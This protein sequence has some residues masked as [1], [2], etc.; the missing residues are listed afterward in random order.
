MFRTPSQAVR[1]VSYP[2]PNAPGWVCRV[3]NEPPLM[4]CPYTALT[5]VNLYY[6]HFFFT[7]QVFADL[8]ELEELDLHF[9]MIAYVAPHAFY[10]LAKLE[11]LD[12]KANMMTSIPLFSLS[13]L[14]SVKELRMSH[15]II[16][17]IGM[18][19]FNREL[20]ILLCRENH[21]DEVVEKRVGE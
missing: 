3:K 4:S 12:M 1:N 21:F 7:T 5:R 2:G 19:I 9:N 13:H 20:L 11:S 14:S 15:N 10:G 17:E 18:A 6:F 16:G 8:R